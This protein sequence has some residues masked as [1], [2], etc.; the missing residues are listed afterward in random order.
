M[1]QDISVSCPRTLTPPHPPLTTANLT[2]QPPIQ[3][4]SIFSTRIIH[5]PS[6]P[7]LAALKDSLLNNRLPPGRPLASDDGT[8]DLDLLD[9]V[10][11]FLLDDFATG[12]PNHA[13]AAASA[14]TAVA[15][16]R[17]AA[18]AG[19]GIIAVRVRAV[20]MTGEES[21]AG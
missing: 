19:G 16:S 4:L 7:A 21:A 1:L 20:A 14:D 18:A 5:K 6:S 17:S 9:L 15:A 3:N 8:E 10:L 13:G 11:V 12:S 2:H